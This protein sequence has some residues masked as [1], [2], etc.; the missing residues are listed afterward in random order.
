MVT[1]LARRRPWR[2]AREVATLDILSGGRVVFGV[3][4]GSLPEEWD[5]FGEDPD[6]RTR[7]RK[8]DEGLEIVTGL[9]SGEPFTY[10][11][12]HY[13]VDVARFLPRPIQQPR[14]PIWIAGRWP[15][16]RP[17]RR[18]AR[19]DGVFATHEDVGHNDNITPEQ[20]RELIE[21]TM[22]QRGERTAPFDVIVEGHTPDGSGRADELV[23]S[24]AGVGLTWWVEKLG[25][26]RGSVDEMQTRVAAGP[27]SF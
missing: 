5:R 14:V 17:F 6:P 19:W 25:W 20:L 9:W 23:A 26:F 24:Y 11:G 4:L 27:P 3:G 13:S 21:Y 10:A 22:Q 2:V 8:I 1:A 7:A 16:R 15:N 12:K 18:A